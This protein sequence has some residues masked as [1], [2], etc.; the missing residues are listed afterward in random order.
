MNRLLIKSAFF[1]VIFAAAAYIIYSYFQTEYKNTHI[2]QQIAAVQEELKKPPPKPIVKEKR[3]ELLEERAIIRKPD[4]AASTP[5]P[6]SSPPAPA[7]S[8][9]P[10]P[11]PKRE[12][13]ITEVDTR[14]VE[15]YYKNQQIKIEIIGILKLQI[16]E[17]NSWETILKLLILILVSYGGIKYINRKFA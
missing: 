7:A 14:P 15:E 6:T 5:A 16:N 8:A 3:I 4:G 13:K 12:I 11:P 2:N 1:I 9:P 17:N 10:P